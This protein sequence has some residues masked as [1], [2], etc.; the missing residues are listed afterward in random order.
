MFILRCNSGQGSRQETVFAKYNDC[1]RY[2]SVSR[3]L[4]IFIHKIASVVR[5]H[6][7]GTESDEI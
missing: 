6:D 5:F 2:V 1:P 3:H 4:A 7:T